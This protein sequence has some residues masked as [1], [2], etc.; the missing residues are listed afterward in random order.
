MTIESR[1]GED[2]PQGIQRKEL[3]PEEW[4]MVDEKDNR[5]E[6]VMR[7]KDPVGEGNIRGETGVTK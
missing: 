6:R 4:G 2:K 3:I 1:E 7:G 5:T